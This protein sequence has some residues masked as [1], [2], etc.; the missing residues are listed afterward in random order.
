LVAFALPETLF[1]FFTTFF[2]TTLPF[3]AICQP[4]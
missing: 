1:F 2:L 4:P 3:T